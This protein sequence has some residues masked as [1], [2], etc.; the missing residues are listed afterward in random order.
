MRLKWRSLATETQVFLKDQGAEPLMM[1]RQQFHDTL[2][3]DVEKWAKVVKTS[4][5]RIE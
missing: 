2:V 1:G 3:S 5:A 4:G